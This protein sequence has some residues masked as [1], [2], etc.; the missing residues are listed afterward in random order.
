MRWLSWALIVF[1]LAWPAHALA[2]TVVSLPDCTVGIDKSGK[3]C[4]RLDGAPRETRIG[5]DRVG[6]L[7]FHR[8]VLVSRA[9][10]RVICS[11]RLD[12]G[13]KVWYE[14][15]WKEFVTGHSWDSHTTFTGHR[16]GDGKTCWH[17]DADTGPYD[18]MF[19]PDR[20]HLEVDGFGTR[21]YRIH[22]RKLLWKLQGNAVFAQDLQRAVVLH[23]RGVEAENR[24]GAILGRLPGTRFLGAVGDHIL[25]AT[26]T[27]VSDCTI[28][29]KARW[30]FDP[31][32]R[33]SQVAVLPHDI[34]VLGSA[35]ALLGVRN[36]H[37][38]WRCVMPQRRRLCCDGAIGIVVCKGEVR[39]LDLA[40]GNILWH[41]NGAVE[42]ASAAA[43]R[44][45]LVCRKDSHTVLIDTLDV[46]TGRECGKV[47]MHSAAS[48]ADDV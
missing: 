37:L 20:D 12:A 44:V 30:Q 10:G 34:F 46:E 40:T 9:T 42:D 25:L 16:D 41:R 27:V 19:L 1:A 5:H 38:L 4:W 32:E 8:F 31:G 11:L 43:G 36:G 21:L 18:S 23:H 33:V 17:L 26:G 22:D 29:L 45:S 15:H 14:P 6:V 35:T 2:Q 47:M 3:L 39:A 7:Q 24:Q 13:D 28:E 48:K